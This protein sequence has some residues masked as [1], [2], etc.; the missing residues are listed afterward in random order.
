MRAI[1]A[2]DEDPLILYQMCVNSIT[3]ENL[4]NRLSILTNEISMTAQDY[5]QK[6]IAKRLYTITPNN[7]GKNEIALGS[8]T[9]KELNEVYSRHMVDKS[10]PAR[11]TYDFL[12]SRAPLNRC[13]FCGI[14][15]ATTLDH[16]LPKTKYPQLSVLSL[17]LIP[18]CKDCNT[19][20]GT[21]VATTEA[22]QNL[23]PYFD[24]D[25]FINEQWLFAQIIHTVPM[26]I[27]FYVEAPVDWD[28]T[29]KKRVSAHFNDFKLAS[30]YSIEASTELS[31]LKNLLSNMQP[32][33]IET[34]RELLDSMA[35]SHSDK[36]QNS[37]QTAMYQILSASTWYC[38]RGFR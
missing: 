36:H 29:S 16:Y 2:P 17:N 25:K 15:Q 21:S 8:V 37:W 35:R 3:D 7:C 24:Q 14:G 1:S 32:M 30:R 18:S 4:R 20:K 9:K 31:F 5:K 13:P 11:S 26:V 33:S 12:L 28:D 34:V 19:G 6:A 27:Q 23:H 38:D 10:K 22:T